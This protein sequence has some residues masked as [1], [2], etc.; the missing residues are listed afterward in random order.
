MIC[1]DCKMVAPD[2]PHY[3]P[4]LHCVIWKAYKRDPAEVLHLYGYERVMQ[5]ATD[6]G[7]VS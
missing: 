1:Q 4:H 2:G 6:A 3:H 5:N 7:G